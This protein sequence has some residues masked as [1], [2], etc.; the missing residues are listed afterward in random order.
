MSSYYEQISRE[1]FQQR[2]AISK[3]NDAVL[4]VIITQYQPSRFLTFNQLIQHCG[5]PGKGVPAGCG[6]AAYLVQ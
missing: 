1:E 2:A 3:L 5:S 6:F 4:S